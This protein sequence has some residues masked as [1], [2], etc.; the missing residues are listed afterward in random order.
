MTVGPGTWHFPQLFTLVQHAAGIGGHLSGGMEFT[1]GNIIHLS[2]PGGTSALIKRTM[3]LDRL[4]RGSRKSVVKLLAQTI[5][6]EPWK[7]MWDVF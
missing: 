4:Q 1:E 3:D 6:K 2:F 7:S 5:E